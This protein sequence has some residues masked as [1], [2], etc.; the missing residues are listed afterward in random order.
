[1]G[2]FGLMCAQNSGRMWQGGNQW[3]AWDSYLTF[4][5][6][7]AKLQLDYGKYN[8]WETLAMHSGPRIV[9]EKFCMISDRPEMLLVDEQNRPHC[10]TG[11]F[12][13][14]R[15]GSALYAVH[16]T[17]V[18]AYVVEQPDLITVEAIDQESNAEVRR[19]M[20]GQFGWPNYLQA[21][22]ARLIDSHPDPLIGSLYELDDR[23]YGKIRVVQCQNGT[24]NPDG[25]PKVYGVPVRLQYKGEP[26]NDV[27]GAIASSYPAILERFPDNFRDAYLVMNQA[28]T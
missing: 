26:L 8:S 1:L 14:W 23:D 3:S 2:K 18:P 10:D 21:K 15:D 11:P 13:K 20:M 5:R 6:H 9:H 28:R 24:P 4:F 19:V 12:C 16:G 27:V 22:N 17:R 25:T 7:V